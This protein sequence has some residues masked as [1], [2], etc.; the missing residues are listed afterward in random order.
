M[1]IRSMVL[2]P[3]EGG[4]AVGFLS[5]TDMVQADVL[6]EC[7]ELR[8]FHGLCKPHDDD[9]LTPP[10]VD[11]LRHESDVQSGEPRR[12]QLMSSRYRVLALRPQL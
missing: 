3:Q 1:V 2:S 7:F 4:A 9:H 5:A 8:P 10:H 6:N 12:P 11:S